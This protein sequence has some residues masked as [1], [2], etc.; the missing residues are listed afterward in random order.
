VYDDPIR[1]EFTFQSESF[2]HTF[3]ADPGGMLALLLE[4][5]PA[6]PGSRWLDAACGPGIVARALA[7]RVGSVHGIDLTE[8]M[9]ERARADAAAAGI[10]NV[11]FQLGDA[12]AIDLADDGF[13]GALARLTVH[14]VPVPERM[15]AEMRRVVRPGGW[16]LVGDHLTDEDAD[17]AAWHEQIERLRD[18]SHWAC[19]TPARM[20]ALGAAAA[21]ELDEER[22]VP[23]EIDFDDWL[24][25]GSGGAASAELIEDLIE[26]PP[27]GA[28]S[29]R[30]VDGGAGR[31]LA[32]RY[33]VGR[34]RVP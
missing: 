27:P 22:L 8:A 9:V 23:I 30:V 7:E 26:R 34:W 13:D 32:L 25:R 6:E 19:Q 10:D 21:L 24:A 14:H 29:F 3:A 20:R 5:T 18:P 31:R 16:V 12:T 33:W 28:E 17:A 11:A 1:S 4:M 2:A 15:L